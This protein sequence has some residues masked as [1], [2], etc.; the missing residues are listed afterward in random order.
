MNTIKPTDAYKS[1]LHFINLIESDNPTYTIDFLKKE[2]SFSVDAK[3][4]IV[5]NGDYELSF[6]TKEVIPPQTFHNFLTIIQSELYNIVFENIY[7]QQVQIKIS[8]SESSVEYRITTKSFRSTIEDT[9]DDTYFCSFFKYDHN[10]FN[11]DKTCIL[12]FSHKPI[13]IK[14]EECELIIF[15][16]DK[17]ATDGTTKDERYLMFFSKNKTKQTTFNRLVDAIRVTWGLI[18]G[19]YIGK[20]VY[21]LSCKPELGLS[22]LNFS[23]NNLQEEIITYRGML[24][25][26]LYDNIPEDETHLTIVEFERLVTLFYNN[27]SFHRAGLFLIHASKDVGL[28]KGGM[29]AVALETITGEIE[30]NVNAKKRGD[31]NEF[32]LP[33]ALNKELENV[34]T[35]FKEANKITDKQQQHYLKKLENFS[36]PFNSDKLSN[37]FRLLKITLS[38]TEKGIIENRN[39]ILHGSLPKKGRGLEFV[40]NLNDDELVFYVSNK[41]IMLC[42][43][44]LFRM[45]DKNIDKRINDWGVTI[46]VKK[47]LI[48]K[49]KYIGNGGIKH[50]MISE[51]NPMEDSPEWLA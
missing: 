3:F 33:E 7:N 42:T 31:T 28:S 11:P 9:L 5:D 19:Y 46:I 26:K 12:G 48:E 16:G 21:Y 23:Y 17:T 14:I 36:T 20:N 4:K 25:S 10:V 51:M 22:E 47:H 32:K 13:E 44:L 24:D 40:A 8:N 15:W 38:K 1:F 34:I 35:R 43:M 2:S 18:S 49:G 29:A 39:K 37:P 27:D 41:L 45:A 50:R 6:S 30:R